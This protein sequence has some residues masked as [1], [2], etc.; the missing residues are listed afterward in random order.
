LSRITARNRRCAASW[1]PSLPS[2]RAPRSRGN[3][4]RGR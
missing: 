4:R 3:W 1:P 2:T